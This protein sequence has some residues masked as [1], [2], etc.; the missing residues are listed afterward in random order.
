MKDIQPTDR[1]KFKLV[2]LSNPSNPRAIKFGQ[3]VW[4]Q[5]LDPADNADNSLQGGSVLTTK[6][7]GPPQLDSVRFADTMS[8]LMTH[9]DGASGIHKAL[10]AV[11]RDELQL[12]KRV[13]HNPDSSKDTSQFNSD[14]EKEEQEEGGDSSD[15]KTIDG[16]G[17][18]SNKSVKTE[19]NP[20]ANHTNSSSGHTQHK[21]QF[22]DNLK[23]ANIC[24]HV[25]LSR[26]V[27]MRKDGTSFLPEGVMSDE[28]ALRYNSRQSIHLGKWSI[29]PAKR[30]DLQKALEDE[31]D[32]NEGNS[33]FNMNNPSGASLQNGFVSSLTPLVIQ[34]DHYCLSTAPPVEY[35]HWPP[36]S[37]TIIRDSNRINSDLA[38][39]Y[40]KK[41]AKSL[42]SNL[43]G[44]MVSSLVS[45]NRHSEN[46]KKL[47]FM[48]SKSFEKNNTINNKRSSGLRNTESSKNAGSHGTTMLED[49]QYGC[50]RKIVHRTA[51]YDFTVDRRC[52]WHFVLFEQFAESF[53][54]LSS[55]EKH[56]QKIMET[57]TM[58][59]KLSKMNREGARK[60]INNCH[61]KIINDLSDQSFNGD[62]GLNHSMSNSTIS[63]A[64]LQSSKS[65]LLDNLPPLLGGEKF[66]RS[67]REISYKTTQFADNA[68]LEERRKKEANLKQYFEEKMSEVLS[69]EENM[70]QLLPSPS[71][72]SSQSN[73]QDSFFGSVGF[74]PKF[75]KEEKAVKVF[76]TEFDEEEED[77]VDDD[78][79]S[80]AD[81]KV[82][83]HFVNQQN[84]SK[85]SNLRTILLTN[86]ANIAAFRDLSAGEQL[87]SMHKTFAYYGRTSKAK[88]P[89]RKSTFSRPKAMAPA[90]AKKVEILQQ[91]DEMIENIFSCRDRM[92]KRMEEDIENTNTVDT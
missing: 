13:I 75:P 6:L 67:I 7:F 12:N 37:S 84:N 47:Y 56:A 34:Q 61:I 24:G 92:Q 2:D 83:A 28:K 3:P 51:P 87:V 23:A 81:G 16:E 72:F 41:Y 4:F 59:L 9:N 70:D 25:S 33:N 76:A 77:D 65:T 11:F 50:V 62:L 85:G 73:S 69:R 90:V 91:E 19:A 43:N 54:A 10:S 80:Q 39:E 44:D 60:H 89:R 40:E 71:L 22:E 45:N 68:Y 31:D 21:H 38:E 66:A 88:T 20:G 14:N 5:C 8:P 36:N 86:P 49:D 15:E 82:K 57:A 30:E 29:Q 55:K 1:L 26:I 63:A 79:E 74:S 46:R 35:R 58:A 52:V 78:A 48:S 42:I 32:D 53:V 18:G 17:G 64:T 27:E